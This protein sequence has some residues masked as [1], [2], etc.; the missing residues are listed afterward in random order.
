[1]GRRP[2]SVLIVIFSIRYVYQKF[3]DTNIL[4]QVMYTLLRSTINNIQHIRRLRPLTLA[5]FTM[6]YL[7]RVF[8][9]ACGGGG[10]GSARAKKVVLWAERSGAPA[11]GKAE[12]GCAER[13]S[14]FAERAASLGGWLQWAEAAASEKQC[15]A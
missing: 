3:I 5:S 2:V 12:K 1:M 13:R 11:D 14:L 15:T 7:V 4:L 6:L 8:R 10:G 9:G